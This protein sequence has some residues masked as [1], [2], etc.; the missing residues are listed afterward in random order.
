MLQPTQTPVTEKYRGHVILVSGDR[1]EFAV[2]HEG[3]MMDSGPTVGSG[4]ESIL[5]AIKNDIDIAIEDTIAMYEREVDR[6]ILDG[7]EADAQEFAN[8]I[9]AMRDA[10]NDDENEH[11]HV[12]G[13]VEQSRFTGNP[14]RRCA[15]GVV[16]L[17]LDD[18]DE[19]PF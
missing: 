10:G 3:E 14:H 11:V 7:R 17:D 19:I 5:D 9:T 18:D 12:W 4:L 16:T 2:T 1:T 15:C 13:P 6:A 8:E